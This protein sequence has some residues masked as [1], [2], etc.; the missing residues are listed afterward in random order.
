MM[1]SIRQD[2]RTPRALF[3]F[4]NEEFHFDL[5]VCA[6]SETAVCEKF[7]DHGSLFRYWERHGKSIWMNPP[8]GR[9][10]RRWVGT[11]FSTALKG[12]TVVCLLP[13]RTDTSWFHDYCLKGEI[14]FLRGRLRFDDERRGRCPFPSMIVVFRGVR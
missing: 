13:A 6:T 3:H 11:A 8:Y 2:W 14:R 5:D 7:F 1:S 9:E 10:L 12:V 4:L